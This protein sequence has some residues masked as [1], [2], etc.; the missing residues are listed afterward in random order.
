MSEESIQKFAL[1]EGKTILATP[2]A[3]V[4]KWASRQE[5]VLTEAT[6]EALKATL[7]R[8]YQVLEG[9]PMVKSEKRTH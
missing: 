4:F 1:I 3:T 7:A 8:M 5:T 2:C 9:M 6:Q